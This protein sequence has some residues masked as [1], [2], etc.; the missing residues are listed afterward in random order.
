MV[1]DRASAGRTDLSTLIA[2][3]RAL[4]RGAETGKMG[5]REDLFLLFSRHLLRRYV[6]AYSRAV[7]CV[8]VS[9]F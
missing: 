2:G 3:G 1:P 6:S 7:C 9:L 5:A 4:G 8:D